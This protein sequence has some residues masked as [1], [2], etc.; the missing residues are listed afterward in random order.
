MSAPYEHYSIHDSTYVIPVDART[1][2]YFGI[3][4]LSRSFGVPTAPSCTI[5]DKQATYSTEPRR[6]ARARGSLATT[7]TP[8]AC[9]IARRPA[10]FCYYVRFNDTDRLGARARSLLNTTHNHSTFLISISRGCVVTL[11]PHQISSPTATH[12][13][14]QNRAGAP[15][16]TRASALACAC[17]PS[18][19]C[20][21]RARWGAAAASTP[22]P[23]ASAAASGP[24]AYRGGRGLSSS[25]KGE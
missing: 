24:Q 22:S 1:A 17:S 25:S 8:A 3:A 14:L 11:E 23:L 21:R 10:C 5:C 6:A 12:A 7:A 2:S 15:P 16:S 20:G 19:A 13:Q 18:A 4:I 9:L